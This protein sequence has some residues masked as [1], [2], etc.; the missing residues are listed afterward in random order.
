MGMKKKIPSDSGIF[1]DLFFK[2][3]LISKT[4]RK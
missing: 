3:V 1:Y 4:K 2:A